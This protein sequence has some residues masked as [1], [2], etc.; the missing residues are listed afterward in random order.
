MPNG[1]RTFSPLLYQPSYLAVVANR[2]GG[3]AWIRNFGLVET[4]KARLAGLHSAD[5]A[6]LIRPTR[7]ETNKAR[8]ADLRVCW[9]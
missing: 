2:F 6:A 3:A 8:S 1:N 9:E 7:A 5:Y 4:N